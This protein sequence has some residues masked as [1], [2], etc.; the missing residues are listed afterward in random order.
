MVKYQEYQIIM[1][2]MKAFSNIGNNIPLK[3][4]PAF[5]IKFKHIKY[6]PILSLF[7]YIFILKR[8]IHPE[9]FLFSYKQTV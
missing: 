1:A 4:E 5:L 7:Y 9:I 8:N 2:F 3:R 6:I